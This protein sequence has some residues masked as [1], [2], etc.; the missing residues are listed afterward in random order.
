LATDGEERPRR[1]EGES[2]RLTAI[3][4]VLR[5][6]RELLPGDPELVDPREEL[7]DRPR[8]LLE[9][10]VA[11]AGERPTPLRELGLGAIQ[12]L[13]AAAD[14]RARQR[15]GVRLA[16]LFTDLVGFSAWALEAGDERALVLLREVS[17][18]VEPAIR[19]QCGE[20]VKCLGDGHMAVFGRAEQAVEAALEAQL[21]LADV[22]VD[23]HR[24]QLRA[25]VHVGQPRK[26]E[27]DYLGVDVNVAARVV[28]AAKGSQLLVSGTVREELDD[29][30]YRFG[31]RRRLGAKG[32]PSDLDVYVV[33]GFADATG[34]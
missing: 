30:R 18:C 6:G 26:V 34:D 32:A 24:P 22:E 23:G 28:A 1:R 19:A 9:R 29:E 4:E 33:K 25:G 2:R 15:G 8:A 14:S 12:L 3:A 11:E 27:A 13:Q 10:Y 7:P 17:D 21:R 5:S 20:L 31:R 16:I